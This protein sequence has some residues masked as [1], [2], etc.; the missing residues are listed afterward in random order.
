M[1][2]ALCTPFRSLDHIHTLAPGVSFHSPQQHLHLLSE[3]ALQL[4]GGTPCMHRAREPG[5]Y[6]WYLKKLEEWLCIYE[7]PRNVYIGVQE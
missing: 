6:S 3:D 1:L 5:D 7:C 2:S 4:A